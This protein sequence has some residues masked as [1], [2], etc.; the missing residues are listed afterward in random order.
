MASVR[1]CNTVNRLVAIIC[2]CKINLVE[3]YNVGIIRTVYYIHGPWRAKMNFRCFICV[4]YGPYTLLQKGSF[5]RWWLG[6]V[7][8][9]RRRE[10]WL[11]GDAA[12]GHYSLTIC[13]ICCNILRTAEFV[14]YL[15]VGAPASQIPLFLIFACL[16]LVMVLMS[17]SLM[18]PVLP[19][20]SVSAAL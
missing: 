11:N 10:R 1:F 2:S 13:Y 18:P 14:T 19:S 9:I 16:E 7:E 6:S 12:F 17:P 5:I 8:S 15:T 4:N 3:K 20:L